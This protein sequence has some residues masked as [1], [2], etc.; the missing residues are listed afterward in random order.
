M[1]KF[2]VSGIPI[3]PL[4]KFVTLYNYVSKVLRK[5]IITFDHKEAWK[6]EIPSTATRTIGLAYIFCDTTESGCS[7][8]HMF[9]LQENLHLHRLDRKHTLRVFNLQRLSDPFQWFLQNVLDFEVLYDDTLEKQKVLQDFFPVELAQ[10]CI[11]YSYLISWVEN[12]QYVEIQPGKIENNSSLVDFPLY[13]WI[14]EKDV[15]YNECYLYK[16][17]EINIEK[18]ESF[19]KRSPTNFYP[20]SW[21]KEILAMAFPFPTSSSLKRFSVTR[22][23]GFISF[24]L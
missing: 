13:I 3:V 2:I 4:E 9:T 16:I 15:L 21:K 14:W 22:E 11:D 8:E 6:L 1:L 19:P 10:I 18:C 7:K 12:G 5:I 23:S 20:D 24:E 17:K